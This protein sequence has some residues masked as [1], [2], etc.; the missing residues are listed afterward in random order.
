MIRFLKNDRP[1]GKVII[2]FPEKILF[3][4]EEKALVDF[5]ETDSVNFLKNIWWIF[6]IIIVI[7]TNVKKITS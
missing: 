4:I 5:R 3:H 2:N 1:L 6:I 7:V